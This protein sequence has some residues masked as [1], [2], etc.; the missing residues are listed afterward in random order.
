VNEFGPTK[1]NSV[2][3]KAAC[4]EQKSVYHISRKQ[5]LRCLHHPQ[6]A[7]KVASDM[8]TPGSVSHSSLVLLLG[9]ETESA[10]AHNDQVHLED[11]SH[12]QKARSLNDP[13]NSQAAFIIPDLMSIDGLDGIISWVFEVE[14][15]SFIPLHM[16][17]SC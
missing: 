9:R 1:E 11:V 13:Q 6:L 12:Q 14:L 7:F 8:L 3:G 17:L 2:P 5:A 15:N 16:L 4:V 10:E